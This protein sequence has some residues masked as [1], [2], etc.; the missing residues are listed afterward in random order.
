MT[1]INQEK[2]FEEHICP[3]KKHFEEDPFGYS[4]L[5]LKKWRAIQILNGD[6]SVDYEKSPEKEELKS[7]ILWMSQSLA[8]I[9][10]AE[11]L[12]LNDPNFNLVKNDFMKGIPHCQYYATVLMLVGYS[13]E[14]TLKN[15][16]IMNDGVEKYISNERKHR[17][18]DLEKLADFVPNLGE[19]DKSILNAL[20]RFTIWAGRYPDPG[21]GKGALYNEIPNVTE[22]YQICAKDIF[23]L[24]TRIT[25]YALTV[26]NKYLVQEMTNSK[27]C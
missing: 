8:L 9:K 17:T 19:K 6:S 22:K 13:L 24:A 15:I 21:F 23:Q 20:S 26:T 1:I 25:K 27:F 14:V 10:A 18:H 16:L 12:L 2:F 4:L 7:P 3:N 11:T 5:A